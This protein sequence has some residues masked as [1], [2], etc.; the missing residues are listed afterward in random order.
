MTRSA[1]APTVSSIGHGGIEAAGTIDVDVIHAEPRQRVRQEVLHR[2]RP[3]VDAEPAAVRAAQR[4]ELHREQRLVAAIPQRP[5]DQQLVVPGAVVVAGVEQ[6][7]AGV[8]RGVDGGDALALVGGAVHAGHAHAA[9]R[10]RERPSGRPSRVDE[11]DG[12]RLMS[13]ANAESSVS[14]GKKAPAS[15]I[16][17]IGKP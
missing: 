17:P 11:A 8:E 7:D 12:V 3:R 10:Q 14:L 5:A 2:G 1:I 16:L 9:E 4:A 15:S 6:R 13:S